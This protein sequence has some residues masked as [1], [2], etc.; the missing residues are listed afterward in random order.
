MDCFGALLPATTGLVSSL[1]DKTQFC[2]DNLQ[3]YIRENLKFRHCEQ[4]FILAWQS[5][6]LFCDLVMDCFSLKASQ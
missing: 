1:R 4:G 3:I 2:R 6:I 5:V